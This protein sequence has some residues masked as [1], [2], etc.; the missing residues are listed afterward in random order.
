MDHADPGSTE[1]YARTLHLMRDMKAQGATIL[2]LA[3]EGDTDVP[4]LSTRM[5]TVPAATEW[6]LPI[7]EVIPLQFFSY[8]MS[9]QNGI[10]V[11]RP[12]NLVKAVVEE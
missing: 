5:L 10:D 1:R 3:N 6:L 7:V 2:A 12:R 9:I 11:D 8:F 4:A